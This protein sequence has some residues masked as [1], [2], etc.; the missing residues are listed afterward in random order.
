MHQ[1]I[2]AINAQPRESGL[3]GVPVGAA[4]LC[5]SRLAYGPRE[6]PVFYSRG[7][8]RAD[9]YQERLWVRRPGVAVETPAAAADAE[10]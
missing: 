7:L 8:F 2:G 1:L 6:R 3:L 4:L 5:I 9:R 10:R